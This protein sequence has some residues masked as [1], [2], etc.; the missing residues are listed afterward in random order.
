MSS[1]GKKKPDPGVGH[2]AWMP[3][4]TAADRLKRSARNIRSQAKNGRLE[5]GVHFRRAEA[6][7]LEVNVEAYLAW[8]AETSPPKQQKSLIERINEDTANVRRT[9]R[10]GDGNASKVQLQAIPPSESETPARRMPKLVP[11]AV[12]AEMVFG[13]YAPHR[14]TLRS[15]VQNGKIL[16]LPVKVGRRFFCSPDARYFD[17]VVERINRIVGSG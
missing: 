2:G 1:N 13:E 5:R 7:G 15:W 6:G 8:L 16:P 14:N 4:E 17:P 11:I 9:A 12:W 10:P 3:L